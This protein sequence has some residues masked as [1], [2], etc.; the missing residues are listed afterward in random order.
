MDSERSS[1]TMAKNSNPNAKYLPKSVG[2][3]DVRSVG[4]VHHDTRRRIPRG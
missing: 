2:E 4:R 1:I 3:R